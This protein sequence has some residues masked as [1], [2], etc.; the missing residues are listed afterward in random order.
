MIEANSTLA[1]R[2]LELVWL[3]DPIDAFIAHVNGSAFVRLPDGQMARFG[4]AG[5][6]GREYTSLGRELVSAGRLQRGTVNLK[7]IRGWARQHPDEVD[8][9]LNRN[10]RFVF[11]TPITGNPRGSRTSR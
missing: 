5:T 6:N 4:Y 11:F 9:F 2:G 8:D 10:E 3:R 1:G 7:T